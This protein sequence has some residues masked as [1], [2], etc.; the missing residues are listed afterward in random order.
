M[1]DFMDAIRA[2]VRA[3]AEAAARA[4]AEQAQREA[5]ARE[6]QRQ[7][8]AQNAS[9][10]Q[11]AQQNQQAAQAQQSQQADQARS[12][13]QAEQANARPAVYTPPTDPTTL[14]QVSAPAKQQPP[15]DPA[16]QQRT[17]K[18]Q[19]A[20]GHTDRW[21]KDARA[22]YDGTEDKRNAGTMKDADWKPIEQKYGNVIAGVQNELRVAANNAAATGQDVGKAVDAK[23]DE[24]TKRYDDPI[25][26]LNLE[27]AKTDFLKNEPTQ[28][29]RNTQGARFNLAVAQEEQA[30]TAAKLQQEE[31]SLAEIPMGVRRA[32]P[33]SGNAV[34]DARAADTQAQAKVQTAYQQYIDALQT[35][36]DTLAARGY[37]QDADTD[38]AAVRDQPHDGS[39][40]MADRGMD[41][42]VANNRV[43][44]AD[45]QLQS[46]N[47]GN[48]VKVPEAFRDQAVKDLEARYGTD[49]G[50]GVLIESANVQGMLEGEMANLTPANDF[51]RE[52]AKTDPATLAMAQVQGLTLDPDAKMDP[53]SATPRDMPASERALMKNNPAGYVMY[54]ALGADKLAPAADVPAT[55]PAKREYDAGVKENG[56]L[57]HGVQQME[58]RSQDAKLDPQAR[59]DATAGLNRMRALMA[60]AQPLRIE[61][62][63]QTIDRQLDAGDVTGAL[64]TRKGAVDAA[65]TP[66]ERA[67]YVEVHDDRFDSA[68]FTTQ[69]EASMDKH[70]ENKTHDDDGRPIVG[71]QT[72]YAD[73][74]GEYLQQ[75]APYLIEEDAATLLDTVKAEYSSEWTGRNDSTATGY[76]D[77][78]HFYHGMAAVVDAADAGYAARNPQ[79][80]PG[81]GPAAQSTASW[82]ADRDNDVNVMVML[83][84]S[85]SSH[86]GR[87]YGGA[88]DAAA[89]GHTSLS[90]AL[91]A[92][93]KQSDDA[94]PM[95]DYFVDK[96]MQRGMEKYQGSDLATEEN[97]LF[98]LD[99]D[100]ILRQTFDALAMQKGDLSASESDDAALDKAISLG[101]PGGDAAAIKAQIREDARSGATVKA[102]PMYV[103]GPG[104][105][106]Y[107]T[108]VFE[109]QGKDGKTLWVDDQG[110]VYGKEEL[111]RKR[112][113]QENNLLADNGTIYF[114]EDLELG[115]DGH[116]S[117]TS[118]DAHIVTTQ[119]KVMGWVNLG[120]AAV[121]AVAGTAL[122]VASGGAAT[123]LVTVAWGGM[124]GSMGYGIGTSWAELDNMADHG[125]SINPLASKEAF[126]QWL[127]VAGSAAGMGG[128]GLGKA[129][130]LAFAGGTRL[131]GSTNPIR[132]MAGGLLSRSAQHYGTASRV[133]NGA[134]FGIGGVLTAQQATAFA[135][136]GGQMSLSEK[137]QNGAM[138]LMGVTQMLPMAIQRRIGESVRDGVQTTRSRLFAGG[139]DATAN[140][141]ARSLA[142]ARTLTDLMPDA[143]GGEAGVRRPGGTRARG[144][145]EGQ[146]G[147]PARPGAHADGDAATASGARPRGRAET[148]ADAPARPA[149][150]PADGTPRAA[151]A[152]AGS[153]PKAPYRFTPLQSLKLGG[154]LMHDAMVMK[155]SLMQERVINT[156]M[157]RA[158]ARA[159]QRYNV[160]S[161]ARTQRG[162]G[163]PPP[164]SRRGAAARRRENEGNDPIVHRT[165]GHAGR[166]DVEGAAAADAPP[167]RI[168]QN[169]ISPM[170]R[171]L[172]VDGRQEAIGVPYGAEMAA[173]ALR[174][175][176][177]VMILTGPL[178]SHGQAE[179]N[180]PVG[181]ASLG[182]YLAS[183]GK[184][185]VY[186]TDRAHARALRKMLRNDLDQPNARVE[187]F[188]GTHLPAAMKQSQALLAKYK[189][190]AVVAVEV[191]GR[192]A[193]H[194]YVLQN[195]E[196]VQGNA[197][198]DQLLVD[199]NDMADVVTIA[200]GDHGNEAG[201][202]AARDR[203]LKD[204]A[205]EDVHADIWS[206]VGADHIVTGMN[207]NLAAQAIGFG[208]QRAMG[209]ESGMPT[210]DQ[211]GAMLDTLARHR[212]RDGVTL[213]P[214]ATS[215]RG[216]NKEV[217]KGAYELLQKAAESLPAGL[218]LT[219]MFAGMQRRFLP[220][221]V[222]PSS[223]GIHLQDDVI[224]ITA[225][226]SSNGGL[227]AAQNI[228]RHVYAM[229]GKAVQVVAFTDHAAGTYGGR[230]RPDL[231]DKV[232]DGVVAAQKM[233]GEAD[234]FACN[235]ACTAFP[236]AL[237]GTNASKVIDLI[238][239]TAPK[240]V[241]EGGRH[242]VVVATPGT[243]GLHAY[244]RAVNDLTGGK[245]KIKEIA[246][247]EWAGAV[248][249]LMHEADGAELAQLKEWIAKYINAK[250]IPKETT[251]LWF[252][253]THYPALARLVREQLDAIGR[254]HVKLVDPMQ[255]QARKGVEVLIDK[256]L[257]D[258]GDLLEQPLD[259]ASIPDSK[260][261]PTIVYTTGRPAEV[262]GLAHAMGR[263][264][265]IRTFHTKFGE[266]ADVTAALELVDGGRTLSASDRVSFSYI[267]RGLDKFAMPR[268][269][270]RAGES[271]SSADH[272]M[273]V[274]GFSVAD[275]MP[276]TDGPPGTAALGAALR[277]AGKRV[278]YAVD[279]ANKPIL[280][281]ILREMGEPLDAIKVFDE[282]IDSAE[283]PARS[284]LEEVRPDRVMAIELPSRNA[285]G[286]KHNMRGVRIDEFNPALDQLIIEANKLGIETL[287]IGDGGNEAG[288][289]NITGLI[290]KGWDGSTIAAVVTVDHLV[291]ASVSNWGAYAVAA[292]VLARAG[293][294]HKMQTPDELR[295]VLQAAAD[296]GAVDGVS[297]ERVPTVDGFRADVHVAVL[298]LYTIAAGG[299]PPTGPGAALVPALGGPATPMRRIADAVLRTIRHG[300]SSRRG[301]AGEP[302]ATGTMPARRDPPIENRSWSLREGIHDDATMASVIDGVHASGGRLDGVRYVAV[303]HGQGRR[304]ADGRMPMK[305][306]DSLE[307]AV[308]DQD[309]AVASGV[310]YHIE[311]VSQRQYTARGRIDDTSRIGTLPLTRQGRTTVAG[312]IALNPRFD[313]DIRVALPDD[314][315][316]GMPLVG[317][318]DGR[319]VDV[320]RQ[321]EQFPRARAHLDLATEAGQVTF[322]DRAVPIAVPQVP[323]HFTV[324]ME[325]IYQHA[326]MNVGTSGPR[327]L[328]DAQALA[329]RI[330]EHPD[331][332]EGMPVIL[333]GCY[334]ADGPVPL[335]QEV[336][337]LLGTRAY[338]PDGHLDVDAAMW[339]RHDTLAFGKRLRVDTDPQSMAKSGAL[340]HSIGE[341]RF[342]GALPALPVVQVTHGG[343]PV[344]VH[345]TA[346]V[347]HGKPAAP[348]VTPAAWSGQAE[349]FADLTLGAQPH[350]VNAPDDHVVVVGSVHPEGGLR[351]DDG[352]PLGAHELALHLADEWQPGQPIVMAVDGAHSPAGRIVAQQVADVMRTE[353]LVPEFG[354]AR[355][356]RS[357]DLAQAAGSWRRLSP[358]PDPY[359]GYRFDVRRDGTVFLR[360]PDGTR[361]RV[362]LEA[363]LGPRLG[364]G[365]GKTVFALGSDKAV[366]VSN[367][368]WTAGMLALERDT[369]RE[370]AQ[371]HK[372][373]TVAT[374][375]GDGLHLFG[376]SAIVYERYAASSKDLFDGAGNIRPERAHLLNGQ[377]RKDLEA[378]MGT[379]RERGLH[380]RDIEFGIFPDGAVKL[381]D[382][383]GVE[384]GALDSHG[385]AAL[386]SIQQMIAVARANE[387]ARA[388]RGQGAEPVARATIGH[389]PARPAR[390][391]HIAVRGKD[392]PALLAQLNEGRHTADGKVY[393]YRLR[394][395]G[396]ADASGPRSWTPDDIQ[397]WGYGAQG[398]KTVRWY[399]RR[400]PGGG[401]A[402]AP[403]ISHKREG[404][405]QRALG[406]DDVIVVSRLAPKEVREAGGF[407]DVGW[408]PADLAFTVAARAAPPAASS[409]PA[410]RARA[411][412]EAAPRADGPDTGNTTN[413]TNG[414]NAANATASG[415][416]PR[417]WRLRTI[418]GASVGGTFAAAAAGAAFSAQ[419]GTNMVL[420]SAT[421]FI[422]RGSVAMGRTLRANKV[423]SR[424]ASHS[425]ADIAWLRKVL[426]SERST[427]AWGINDANR[428]KFAKAIDD[429]H[430]YGHDPKVKDTP[431]GREKVKAAQA[432]L[433]TVGGALLTPDTWAGRINDTLQLGTLA[434]N[435]GNTV[436]W[437]GEHGVGNLSEPLTYSNAA[438]LTANTVLSTLNFANRIAYHTG[439]RMPPLLGA[440]MQK[441]VMNGYTVGAAPLA[442]SDFVRNGGV[443][444]ALEA[445][446]LAV[447]GA[448]AHLQSRNAQK[449]INAERNKAAKDADPDATPRPETP[450]LARSWQFFG[451]AM[452]KG[453]VL[454]GAGVIIN[455]VAKIV[456]ELGKD[457]EDGKPGAPPPSG[458]PPTSAA[459]TAP[460]SDPGTDRPATP[461][462]PTKPP[463]A[464]PR[465]VSVQPYSRRN[466]AGSTLWG[467]AAGNLDTLLSDDQKAQ[468][469]AANM[470]ED[471]QVAEFALRELI[472]LNPKYNLAQNP[473]HIEP[474]WALDV[475]R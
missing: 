278:T 101:A 281:A 115:R 322:H 439:T 379:A 311:V 163:P 213:Q 184:E 233:E 156:M 371:V 353:V 325:G 55:D 58:A 400:D 178:T 106:P 338:A 244:A 85:G 14:T 7:Q 466:T 436:L 395:D 61:H 136:H 127:N 359:A 24:I 103:T 247:E 398:A 470:T 168:E 284:L 162:E 412:P 53:N 228:A 96:A 135:Q 403:A 397:G 471:Q 183:L 475:T 79:A 260:T 214:R 367:A 440:R 236:E 303:R 153:G 329:Q 438:F 30:G 413:G 128:I 10:A 406:D 455:F 235:T 119:E 444:G 392:W 200:V 132:Q 125:R 225:F 3:A 385:G 174:D 102:V 459:P 261:L 72:M 86:Q 373:P 358:Q 342:H 394:G 218:D 431:E 129:A 15:A 423:T 155:A 340:V 257:I 337:T 381:S 365:G 401:N 414:T 51:E 65:Q 463:G 308:L 104:G 38:L 60:G 211:V 45:A 378:I 402:R 80:A 11:Q 282:P 272:V 43:G 176:D 361:E 29:A 189:P 357:V 25:L 386:A 424:A 254:G 12:P 180:G 179:T 399:G 248:N 388:A 131:A 137:V 242:P 339:S 290:P 389:G 241:T 144:D 251:S 16:A 110:A 293:K 121:G 326:D 411:A 62:L 146:P 232:H 335:V 421:C 33:E 199:A 87:L 188:T 139:P 99:R 434:I 323:G 305:A 148:H 92:R 449:Q 159:V 44:D 54:K 202:R 292:Q 120:V 195:G 268:G 465:P 422:Y 31:A 255:Y 407:A 451:R 452:P 256:G 350:R 265:D 219:Q 453:L 253:C 186:V 352:S 316:D 427:R 297:R 319:P 32:D 300:G 226:D 464:E 347:A 107:Q 362:K 207:S 274:T 250:D 474:G 190:Q 285:A 442:V 280:E 56:L 245:L 472:N 328:Y 83:N 346:R 408:A 49:G 9:N 222:D 349:R 291:T 89:N 20:Q 418:V 460:P 239:Q 13:Q 140:S 324:R 90:V 42:T 243:V 355:G 382:G 88:E 116:A 203:I 191:A 95:S 307:Q 447:F 23:A 445:G 428:D 314:F 259:I 375:G 221:D 113:F 450:L 18:E 313:G 100:E 270:E 75:V 36:I 118:M 315:H 360:R 74:V 122:M 231:I 152:A 201:M 288:M 410:G 52:L 39:L 68:L 192:N 196:R 468:A 8:N 81:S 124:L 404:L 216:F 149:T 327:R 372:L 279:S 111:D 420:S 69:I 334:G 370:V 82:F 142:D 2:A 473:D 147:T 417:P 296:A 276:E 409:R 332:R 430:K 277:H 437:F 289:G 133:L 197:M 169:A 317:Q 374:F 26:N 123:P 435:N 158:F 59:A 21:H 71:Q 204:M 78:D 66:E 97:K 134:G 145:V 70:L 384:T 76:G 177:T 448:G 433:A 98:E 306:Y 154:A 275:G 309:G 301:V 141:A 457:D 462:E 467:I 114:A 172:W 304:A 238:M 28:E 295:R 456:V 157:D 109:F 170:D 393:V 351:G 273:L 368:E 57:L 366:G 454:L 269:A 426:T 212:A 364:S 198:L 441:F 331:Y 341:G 377:S 266:A 383:M 108:A 230:E 258:R 171:V 143:R 46:L 194:Q 6:A 348:E 117:Y 240:I 252:C 217:Q 160:E 17:E 320:L 262:S 354:L 415:D 166:A 215:V 208:V 151:D 41:L 318:R 77:W 432:V 37:K 185:V 223:L 267:G 380:L 356:D 246:A 396:G 416:G 206:A 234:L 458:T 27:V 224:V 35:E 333:Y 299:E 271:L 283:G 469:R 73:K 105:A 112:D 310:R 287:G 344:P 34:A 419:T 446:S 321:L 443:V 461:T 93:L 67:L 193:N 363:Y 369:M 126:S 336:A 175:L 4:A 237:Q 91:S 220:K 187:T 249:K 94:P 263:R 50:M 330:R 345:G 312:E 22:A 5:Q 130:S 390:P 173:R 64:Q 264:T 167:M 227:L 229:T 429:L 161:A 391:A 150:P 425:L 182:A 165:I 387:A 286:T 210:V 298:T 376:N 47:A 209:H 48:G 205:R 63:T 302:H 1:L 164:A 40:S 19:Q 343:R 181:A 84:Q 138:L 294:I 405:G